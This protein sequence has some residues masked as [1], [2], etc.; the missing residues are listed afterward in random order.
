MV[1]FRVVKE[2]HGWAIRTGQRMTTPFWSKDLAIREAGRLAAAIRRHGECTEVV[3]DDPLTPLAQA[4][5]S[6]S[7]SDD[8]T[9]ARLA[10]C[11]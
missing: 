2:H 7:E 5:N 8:F 3:I 1:I 9:Q 6:T 10:I 11:G 4:A